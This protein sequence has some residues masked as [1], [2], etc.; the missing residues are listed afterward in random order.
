[1]NALSVNNH[2][3]LRFRERANSWLDMQPKPRGLKGKKSSVEE[4]A[5]VILA[6]VITAALKSP[7]R[8]QVVY[9]SRER[10]EIC[11]VDL[12]E[13]LGDSFDLHAVLSVERDAVIT[14]L[15]GT[16]VDTNWESKRWLKKDGTPRGMG[17]LADKLKGITLPPIPKL[18]PILTPLPAPTVP[19]P[20]PHHPP[21]VP[22]PKPAIITALED[23]EE[24]RQQ[25]KQNSK[26]ERLVEILVAGK[27]KY[28]HYESKEAAADAIARLK[29]D[30][31]PYAVWKRV[32]VKVTVAVEEE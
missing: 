24:A 2:A 6:E 5:R 28:T 11:V 3:V 25:R 27:E 20:P 21:V 9:D 14:V 18:A 1:M 8:A 17:T 29:L 15:D 12:Y 10:R 7:E 13:A 4:E 19:M 30:G 31:T 22:T 23:A 16:M 32:I 26:E